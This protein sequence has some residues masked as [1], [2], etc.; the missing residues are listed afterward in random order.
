MVDL[1]LPDVARG[2]AGCPATRPLTSLCLSLLKLL[3]DCGPAWSLPL[4]G[5][6]I[7]D[8]LI[9]AYEITGREEFL[10]AAQAI[11]LQFQTYEQATFL[12]K[13]E[14][15]N[16]HGIAARIPVLANF[17]RYYRHSPNYRPDVGEKI[18]QMVARSERL[19]AKPG[20]SSL[21]TTG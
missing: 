20:H 4:A 15:W 8:T 6:D 11:I 9:Q 2:V 5:F 21:P 7:P 17:W 18:L 10:T 19:L 3:E 13:G 12:P 14:L 16:D 1:N